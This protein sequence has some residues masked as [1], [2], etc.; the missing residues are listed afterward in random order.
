MGEHG[1]LHRE[2]REIAGRYAK[3]FTADASYIGRTPHPPYLMLSY[4]M[5]TRHVGQDDAG[6]TLPDGKSLEPS[7]PRPCVK[8]RF[9]ANPKKPAKTHCARYALARERGF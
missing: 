4:S 7:S 3:R 8:V 9:N 2:R 5:M 1:D 6:M